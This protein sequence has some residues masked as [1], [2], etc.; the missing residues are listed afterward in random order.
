MSETDTELDP[1]IART[2]DVVISATAEV[3]A[4]CGFERITIEA[5]A[6][7]SGVAR[8]TIYRNWPTR[9]DLFIAGFE[10]V[11][12]FQPVPDLGSLRTELHQ[13]G[14][15]LAN[16]LNEAVWGL[17][18]PSLIGSAAH[19]PDLRHAQEAFSDARRTEVA[20]VFIRAAERGEIDASTNAGDLAEAFAG[21][22]F[23][24]RLMTNRPL[25]EDFVQRQVDNAARNAGT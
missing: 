16:G 3:L 18:L 10:R 19:D 6:E 7:R 23:F 12:S 11:C 13:L 2:R 25:D 1:R 8:S 4:E 14:T 24:R 17:V 15:L 5:I 20:E 22:F 9:A 21:P